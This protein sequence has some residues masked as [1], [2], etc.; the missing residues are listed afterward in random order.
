MDVTLPSVNVSF[1]FS[2]TTRAAI[3]MLQRP[4]AS[5]FGGAVLAGGSVLSA[6]CSLKAGN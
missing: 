4:E 6:L 3:R 2:H 5:V 1:G